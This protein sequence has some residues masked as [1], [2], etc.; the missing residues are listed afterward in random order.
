MKNEKGEIRYKIF[1]TVFNRRTRSKVRRQT[2]SVPTWEILLPKTRH[3]RSL[4]AYIHFSSD[5]VKKRETRAVYLRVDTAK[6]RGVLGIYD[7]IDRGTS[8][9]R[10]LILESRTPPPLLSKKSR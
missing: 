2:P 5:D 1:S 4:L 6:T 3:L 10:H 7:G 9:E 8:Y